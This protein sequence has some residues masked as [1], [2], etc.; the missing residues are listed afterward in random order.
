LLIKAGAKP[1]RPRSSTSYYHGG[2]PQVSSLARAVEFGSPE[3]V[4]ALIA[5]GADVN[6][7]DFDGD[8]LLCDVRN[9]DVALALINAGAN[10]NSK[11]RFDEDPPFMRIA[12]YCSDKSIKA[13]IAHGADPNMKDRY[14]ET[15]LKFAAFS[16]KSGNVKALL[17]AGAK[18]DVYDERGETP[19]ICASSK[20]NNEKSIQ[21]LVDAGANINE[22]DYDGLCPL[23][24]AGENGAIGNMKQ[25]LALGGNPNNL[26]RNKISVLMHVADETGAQNELADAIKRREKDHEGFSSYD[27]SMVRM[28]QHILNMHPAALKLLLSA[29]ATMNAKD[30]WGKTVLN[31][32]EQSHDK[33]LVDLLISAGVDVNTRDLLGK[34]A[35]D[36]AEQSNDKK[37]IDVLKAAGAKE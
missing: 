8:P 27:D 28:Y 18:P 15:P 4:K 12:Q 30:R 11:D 7:K 35:L 36:Y 16:G 21:L 13:M 24:H 9:D 26:D 1:S 32:A 3:I 34:T 23:S 19:L 29:G 17:D 10:V 20:S 37:L 25:L 33:K 14:Q 6:V 5:A 31:Y 2:Y 22:F